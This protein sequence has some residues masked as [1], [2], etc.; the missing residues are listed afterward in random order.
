MVRQL[1]S[2]EQD[3]WSR[4]TQD[5]APLGESSAVPVDGAPY[6]KVPVVRNAVFHPKIDLHGLTIQEAYSTVLDHIANGALLG[7]KR[8][9]IVSGKSGQ[10]NIELPKWAERHSAVRSVEPFNGGGAWEICLKKAGT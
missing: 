3:L 10:I 6:F 5:V 7:Y 1:S 9:T 2:D 4:V 8:L